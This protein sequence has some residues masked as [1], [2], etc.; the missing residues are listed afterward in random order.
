MKKI[1]RFRKPFIVALCLV[2]LTVT[3]Y[4]AGYT[5][6]ITVTYKDI[7]L[8]VDGVEVT[9][10]D[11]NGAEVEPFIYNGT[12]Y[13]PIRAIGSALGKQV[14]WDGNTNTAYL[15]DNLGVSTFLMDVCPPYDT[16]IVWDENASFKMDGQTYGHG[17]TMGLSFV[18]D[19]GYAYIN[20]DG[21]YSMMEFDFGATDGNTEKTFNYEIYLDGQLVRTITHN[22]GEMVEHISIPLD[23]ALQLKIVAAGG[24]VDYFADSCGFANITVQ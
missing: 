16:N 24:E 13:L 8:V 9:P 23:N 2:L 4:A 18:G 1:L 6:T 19:P 17:F 20:L 12:T 10:K 22:P 21:N 7:K 15:G 3:A 14:Q 11:A 5:Q